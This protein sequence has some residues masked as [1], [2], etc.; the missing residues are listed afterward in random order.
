MLKLFSLIGLL[1][2][3]SLENKALESDMG[4][5]FHA[6]YTSAREPYGYVLTLQNQQSWHKDKDQPNITQKLVLHSEVLK[7]QTLNSNS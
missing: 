2:P 5:A 7:N 4:K 1:N 3:R 6:N